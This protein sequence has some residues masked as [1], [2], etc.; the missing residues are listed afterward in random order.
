MWMKKIAAIKLLFALLFVSG[1]IAEAGS[2]VIRRC[3]P[4][5]ECG[6]NP[7][8]SGA[9]SFQVHGGIVPLQWRKRGEI[10]LLSCNAN[11]TNPVFQLASKFPKFRTLY[12]LPWTFGGIL[13]YAW[14][15]NVEMYVEFNYL[16]ASRK[17]AIG[18]VFDFPNVPDQ[19]LVIRLA[20]YNLIDG[21]VGVRY[22]VDRFCEWVSPFIGIKVGFT[23]HRTVNAD[24]TVNGVPVVLVPAAGVD[25]CVPSA[26]GANNRFFSS[27]TLIAGGFNGGLDICFCGG[28]SFTATGEFVVSCGPRVRTA[29]VFV[30]QLQPPTLATNL[31]L[32]GFGSEL[33]FP[34]TFG[35]KKT[36]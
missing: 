31:I 23:D 35:I 20:K 27:S 15:D 28:W 33:R 3:K 14:S 32:G 19:S 30:T 18:F 13:G 34:I 24:L 26:T 25:A 7:L 5:Y 10:D 36:F 6:C 2:E 29:S 22:Y 9:Y 8:Y 16:Q 4:V 1:G 12:K 21:Y 17:N 11:P